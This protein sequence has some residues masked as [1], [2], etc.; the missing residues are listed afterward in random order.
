MQYLE[1]KRSSLWK[2]EYEYKAHL[3]ASVL[4]QEGEEETWNNEE[5]REYM[6]EVKSFL[7][8][9]FSDEEF[10]VQGAVVYCKTLDSIFWV[11]LRYDEKL[12]K[13]ERAVVSKK[14]KPSGSSK[15]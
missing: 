12:L 5:D 1:T 13:I 10:T 15:K 2:N 7:S 11:R 3:K 8:H 4:W 14:Q 9:K 6:G